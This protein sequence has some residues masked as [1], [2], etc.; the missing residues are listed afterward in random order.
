MDKTYRKGKQGKKNQ[1]MLY[2]EVKKQYKMMLTPTAKSELTKTATARNISVSELIE[3]YG[4]NINLLEALLDA[5][6]EL[7]DDA[8]SADECLSP[9]PSYE[10]SGEAVR[11]LTEA[12]N[13]FAESEQNL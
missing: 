4:R 2:D 3:R 9:H 6:E 10:V 12:F 11:K 5:V 1:P 7:I 8:A 13:T